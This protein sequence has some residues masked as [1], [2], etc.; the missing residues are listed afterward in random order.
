MLR[1]RCADASC[2][3]LDMLRRWT[4]CDGVWK[5]LV[6]TERLHP[7]ICATGKMLQDEQDHSRS[8]LRRR[9]LEI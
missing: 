1:W 9:L 7:P 3:L 6:V 4:C 8:S 5:L 2:C